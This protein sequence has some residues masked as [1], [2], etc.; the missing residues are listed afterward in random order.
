MISF[1][2]E[3]SDKLI[4]EI[5]DAKADELYPAV[6]AAVDEQDTLTVS[7]IVENELH[8]QVLQQQS[9]KLA[10]SIREIPATQEGTS[11][12]GKVEG[13]GGTAWYGRGYE[14]EGFAPHD[15]FPVNAKALRFSAPSG[16]WFAGFGGQDIVYAKVVHHPGSPPRPFMAPALAARM[17]EIVAGIE[18][19]I[20][21]VL[22]K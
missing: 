16:R 20:G 9:G 13:A 18:A 7:Y 14:E 10:G 15:I 3:G 6:S 4:L 21:E 5:V 17:P 1:S 12:V 11:I 22:A 8:G 19:A 2:F